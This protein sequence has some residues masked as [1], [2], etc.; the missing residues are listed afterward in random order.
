MQIGH[1][2]VREVDSSPPELAK[3]SMV[4][5]ESNSFQSKSEGLCCQLAI[6]RTIH[7]EKIT[8]NA[9]QVIVNVFG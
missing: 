9:A 7:F 2:D 5:A 3:I 8:I 1:P 6:T 4:M